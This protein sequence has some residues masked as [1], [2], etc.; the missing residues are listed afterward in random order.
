MVILGMLL[1]AFA[2]QSLAQG[3]QEGIKVHGHWV[4]DV[5]NPDGTL[6]S[7]AEFENSLMPQGAETLARILGRTA[8]NLLGWTV[9]L[10]PSSGAPFGS[11]SGI[12]MWAEIYE[13]RVAV[14]YGSE[15]PWTFRSLVIAQVDATLVLKGTATASANGQINDVVTLLNYALAV[16][17]FEGHPFSGTRL[18][19]PIALAA[20]Q[21]IQVTVT[22][23]FS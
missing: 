12:G 15:L 21:N 7:H 18:P 17:D 23:S 10:L 4:I 13:S 3:P 8:D 1:P 6:A 5:R 9:A 11:S 22:L 16:D 20:G 14:V 19:A 2:S